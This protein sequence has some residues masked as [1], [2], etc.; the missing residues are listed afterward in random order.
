MKLI[1]DVLDQQMVDAKD[2]KFG[3]VD[4]LVLE[5]R[6]DGTARVA[7]IEEGAAVLARRI[8]RRWERWALALNR[9]LGIRRE[10][11]YRVPWDKVLDVGI[12]VKVE[13]DGK[14]EPPRDW[15]R[16]LRERVLSKLPFA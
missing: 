5:V 9:R 8:G 7:F 3:K 1:G 13:I 12:D 10:P 14:D 6:D 2:C 16:W 15:E 11:R 4:G